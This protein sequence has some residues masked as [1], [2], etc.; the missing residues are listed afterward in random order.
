MWLVNLIDYY[1]E[2][3][4]KYIIISPCLYAIGTATEEILYGIVKARRTGK[5]LLIIRPR[6]PESL[7]KYAIS[8]PE[9]YNIR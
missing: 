9:I 3:N 8:N 5:K 2:K 6:L 7:C 1:S 4:S